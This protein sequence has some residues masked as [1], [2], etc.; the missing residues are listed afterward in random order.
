MIYITIFKY[1]FHI[2]FW[3]HGPLIIVF[4]NRDYNISQSNFDYSVELNDD[5]CHNQAALPTDYS[6]AVQNTDVLFRGTIV[7]L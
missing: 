6:T 1:I 5:F 4:N 2:K 3:S 7:L